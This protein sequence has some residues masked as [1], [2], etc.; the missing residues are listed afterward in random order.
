VVDR[1]GRVLL[2][3]EAI[4]EIQIYNPDSMK[5]YLSNIPAT[6][7]AFT[8][9]HWIRTGDIGYVR[10]KNWYIVDRAKDLIKVRGWQVSPAEIE[11]ALLEHPD[12]R[13]AGVIGIPAQDGCGESPMAFIVVNEGS[14]LDESQVKLFLATSL[15]RYKNVE[16]VNF[17]GRIPRNPIGK[18]LRR[19]L[20]D[21]R[22]PGQPTPDQAAA[23]AYATGLKKI[24]VYEKLKV[25]VSESEKTLSSPNLEAGESKPVG[26]EQEMSSNDTGGKKRK[27]C[28]TSHFWQWRKRRILTRSQKI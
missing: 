8:P 23:K 22:G 27:L 26:L 20:R 15:A 1:E 19:V 28:P 11:S 13:D 9:D 24:S 14:S 17:I 2:K 12:I 10:D 3:Q 18:I 25:A 21:M 16:E 6:G 7:E 5:G 4:G